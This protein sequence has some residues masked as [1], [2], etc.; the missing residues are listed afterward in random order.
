MLS[1]M[2]LLNPCCTVLLL[3]SLTCRAVMACEI[4]AIAVW[5]PAHLLLYLRSYAGTWYA[6]GY[7]G[8]PI[9]IKG[10][11][12]LVRGGSFQSSVTML[13]SLMSY[14]ICCVV[15]V[16]IMLHC[17]PLATPFPSFSSFF[18][19][20]AVWVE[21]SYIRQAEQQCTLSCFLRRC[22]APAQ[23]LRMDQGQLK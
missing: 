23:W 6:R 17:V 4:N 14:G 3:C 22:C 20:L 19:T 1:A 10:T 18:T 8:K 21:Q 12:Y 7:A 15:A 11:D 2:H 9:S 16:L 13:P 5:S